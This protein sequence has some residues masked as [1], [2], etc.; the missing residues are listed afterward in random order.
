[1]GDISDPSIADPDGYRHIPNDVILAIGKLVVIAGNLEGDADHVIEALGVA[2]KRNLAF[3]SLIGVIKRR[4]R[5][6]GVPNARLPI[7]LNYRKQFVGGGFRQRLPSASGT[8]SCIHSSIS[9]A[10]A[11]G[12]LVVQREHIRPGE[13]RDV[14]LGDLDNVR[15]TLEQVHQD[16]R[17]LSAET[18]SSYFREFAGSALRPTGSRGRAPSVLRMGDVDLSSMPAHNSGTPSL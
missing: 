6:F 9:R 13:K 16:G 5:D 1:V 18:T 8:Q 7:T 2:D 3:E 17:R 14:T 11:D 10:N 4:F 12:Q 15:L